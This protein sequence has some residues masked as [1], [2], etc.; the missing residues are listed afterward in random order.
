[1]LTG[2]SDD[3]VSV[4][5]WMAWLVFRDGLCLFPQVALVNVGPP[6][7]SGPILSLMALMGSLLLTWMLS[8]GSATSISCRNSV[9]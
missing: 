9:L 3:S 7:F 4:C 2:A 1:M 6:D 8:L 5:H